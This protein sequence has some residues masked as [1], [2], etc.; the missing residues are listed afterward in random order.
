MKKVVLAL[1]S[2]PWMVAAQLV[3]QDFSTSAL[4]ADYVSATPGAGQ[5]NSIS[6]SG[7]GVAVSI[8][9][10]KL[11]YVRAGANTGSFTR[12]TD[13]AGPPS[14]LIFQFDLTFSG[15]TTAATS[16][17]VF[18]AGSNF[19]TTNTTEA[20]ADV[21]ARFTLNTTATEGNFVVRDITNGVNSTTLTGTTRI[22]WVMNNSGSTM[23]YRA[24]D[25]NGA[26]VANDK[27]DI[28]GGSALLFDD[29]S[30]QSPAQS[31]TDI[32]FI[33]NQ[34]SQILDIDNML[35]DPIPP[36]VVSNLA[37]EVAATSFTANWTTQPGV[38]GYRLDV[39]NASDFSSYVTGFDGLFVSGAS[40]SSAPVTGLQ[41]GSVYYY[42]LRASSKYTVGEWESDHSNVTSVITGLLPVHFT[43]VTAKRVDEGTR[44][45]FTNATESSL[46]VY[47]VQRSHNGRDFTICEN[48]LP[49]KNN[50]TAASYSMVDP[51]TMV[52]GVFYRVAAVAIDGSVSFS[53]VV[54]V[55][56]EGSSKPV[57]QVSN[58]VCNKSF[59]LA[60]DQLPPGNYVFRIYNAQGVCVHQTRLSGRSRQL[61]T[62][63]LGNAAAGI[64]Y[65]TLSGAVQLTG[66]ITLVK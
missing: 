64:Y 62:M 48:I 40:T 50:E 58:P 37:T 13:L 4:V 55:K 44:I 5:F 56:P 19:S 22:T 53:A 29:V 43:S 8:S 65:W 59:Q 7:A 26:S 49:L 47:Q 33:M 51:V 57:V 66:K 32:K 30:V 60:A 16:V 41:W 23:T 52:S 20:N 36:A 1:F 38:S 25:G 10:G 63:D 15:S 46:A 34:G 27:A 45:R 2:W 6:S 17:C 3:E 18:Y 14:T 61:I 9:S 24:P 31:I 28:W 35:A 11:R 54:S 21:Y 39:S 12:N 42:R